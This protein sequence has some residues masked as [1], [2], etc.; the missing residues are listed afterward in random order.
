MA[1]SEMHQKVTTVFKTPTEAH[2]GIIGE[3]K[4]ISNQTSQP[5]YAGLYCY[6]A[7]LVGCNIRVLTVRRFVWV[8]VP[9]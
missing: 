8:S 9:Y 1:V 5:L 2:G 6:A 3:G 4:A 7:V